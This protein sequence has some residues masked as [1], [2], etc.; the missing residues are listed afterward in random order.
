MFKTPS[1]PRTAKH[2]RAV[3][4]PDATLAPIWHDCEQFLDTDDDDEDG[5]DGEDGKDD[6]FYEKYDHPPSLPQGTEPQEYLLS[7]GF[8]PPPLFPEKRN[9]DPPR[10][11]SPSDF[12]EPLI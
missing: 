10:A 11:P 12:G 4:D 8:P 2:D 5:E 6:P 9:N 3:V 1:F 7:F